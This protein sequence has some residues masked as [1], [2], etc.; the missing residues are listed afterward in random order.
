MAGRRWRRVAVVAAT[1]LLPV[2]AW[3][4][5]RALQQKLERQAQALDLARL[6]RD[7]GLDGRVDPP[8]WH[9][10]RLVWFPRPQLRLLE[11]EASIHSGRPGPGRTSGRIQL[12]TVRLIPPLGFPLARGLEQVQFAGGRVE[13]GSDLLP[14]IPVT[15]VDPVE[16]GLRKVPWTALLE[17]VR[18]TAGAADTEPV[19]D[20]KFRSID[21]GGSRLPLFSARDLDLRIVGLEIPPDRLLGLDQARLEMRPDR[22]ELRGRLR[23]ANAAG[24][25]TAVPFL[26]VRRQFEEGRLTWEARV[27]SRESGIRALATSQPGEEPRWRA[28]LID[29]RGLVAAALLEGRTGT[30]Q[31]VRWEGPWQLQVEGAGS[32]P[33]GLRESVVELTG[34][35][36]SLEGSS[37]PQAVAHGRLTILPGR[38]DLP[39][40]SLVDPYGSGDSAQVRF[41]WLRTPEGRR[42]D[43]RIEGRLDPAW[44]ALFGPDWRARGRIEF[45]LDFEGDTEESVWRVSPRGTLHGDLAEFAGPWFADTLRHGSLDAWAN[46]AGLGCVVAGV[47]GQS[48]FR[49]ET[50]RLPDPAP[51]YLDLVAAGGAWSLTSPGCRFEDFRL[52]TDRFARAGEAPFWLGLPGRGR[53]QIERGSIR[54][55]EF[56]DLAA[57][58]YRSRGGNRVDSLAVSIAGGRLENAPDVLV[59]R[60]AEGVARGSGVL[61]LRGEGLDVATLRELLASYG[62]R[63]PGRATGTLAGT[64]QIR[65]PAP[66]APLDLAE[67]RASLR[68]AG[69]SLRD[70]PGQDALRRRTGLD[71]MAVLSFDSMSFDLER[72]PDLLR[73]DRLRIVAPDFRAE[74]AGRVLRSRELDAVVRVR[75]SIGGDLGRVLGTLLGD[76]QTAV[77][78]R[79]KG[80]TAV[81]EVALL[82]R[83]AFRR[84]LDGIGGELPEDEHE[85]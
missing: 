2:A 9:G 50:R 38:V 60:R 17:L 6:L 47:W 25:E 65:W 23:V 59:S 22:I 64:F 43:G 31:R 46:S 10:S 3:S 14:D 62:V 45:A 58:L 71:R 35:S 54:G 36:I 61:R 8:R 69:G 63:V 29:R 11:V 48:V 4:G 37:R 67:L 72:R 76:E 68:I 42:F 16:N 82:S 53:I 73:W 85:P 34:G 80:T 19:D 55:V 49:L 30:L 44:I 83:S 13:V 40:L 75:P 81:P 18:A 1:V 24:T 26:L 78:A 57:S 33:A 20:G 70:L 39:S 66:G 7:A 51:G 77:Y 52:N 15:Y 74:G 12:E 79:V 32:F 27:G 84:A 28:E 56:S 21:R 5:H 41:S